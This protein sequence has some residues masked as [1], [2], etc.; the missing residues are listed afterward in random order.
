MLELANGRSWGA[1]AWHTSSSGRYVPPT[2][3]AARPA[4]ALVRQAQLPARPI[5]R[6][7]S[8]EPAG[9]H[10]PQGRGVAAG[11]LASMLL[12]TALTASPD[13]RMRV[14]SASSGHLAR[15][16]GSLRRMQPAGLTVKLISEQRRRR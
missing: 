8:R 9:L 10:G 5:W 7:L 15:S 14:G 4:R 3:P 13:G 12:S 16:P 11:G 6:G 2:G 1:E